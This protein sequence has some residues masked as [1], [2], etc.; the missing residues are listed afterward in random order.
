MSSDLEVCS[1]CMGSGYAGHP[2]SGDLCSACGGSGGERM[3]S[4]PE[5]TEAERTSYWQGAYERMAALNIELSEAAAPFARYGEILRGQ[6]VRGDAVMVELGDCKVTVQD[7][8]NISLLTPHRRT[9]G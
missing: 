8:R 6:K 2:D 4:E 5:M 1:Q 3:I 9:D 7:F